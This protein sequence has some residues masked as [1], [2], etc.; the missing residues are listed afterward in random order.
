MLART[1]RLRTDTVKLT[2]AGPFHKK[3]KAVEA[4]QPLGFVEVE[5]S[6]PWREA[7]AD[8]ND[9][10]LPGVTLAGAR[11]KEGLTQSELAKIT[12]IPQRH[13]SEM[14]HGKRSIGR[15]RAKKLAKALNVNFRVFL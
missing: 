9:E 14:E 2:F 15:D 1:R 8:I 11:V 7:F 10:Q 4:L 5:E 3:M 6:V 13:I 12:G